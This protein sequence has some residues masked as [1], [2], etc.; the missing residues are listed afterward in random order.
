MENKDHCQVPSNDKHCQEDNDCSLQDASLQAF[1]Q[2]PAQGARVVGRPAR[3]QAAVGSEHR[4]CCQLR[5]VHC[6]GY[7][8][9]GSGLWWVT[10]KAAGLKLENHLPP[11]R[12]FTGCLQPPTVNG[13]RYSLSH[14]VSLSPYAHIAEFQS[15]EDRVE[16]N[17]YSLWEDRTTC[18]TLLFQS[19]M[20]SESSRGVTVSDRGQWAVSL[21][22]TSG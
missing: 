7:Y 16:G 14:S 12:A 11:T 18:L 1:V 8:Q 22:Q 17:Q 21:Q 6:S 19:L 15:N 2:P 3:K 10:H 20:A 4:V 9:G 5:L 13:A